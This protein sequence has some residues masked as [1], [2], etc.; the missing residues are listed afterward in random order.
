MIDRI[1]RRAA[2]VAM[3]LFVTLGIV[4]SAGR[5]AAQCATITVVN[6]A[7][8][9]IDVTFAD[10]NTPVTTMTTGTI[11]GGGGFVVLT[12]PTTWLGFASYTR[13]GGGFPIP[14]TAANTCTPFNPAPCASVGI[15]GVMLRCCAQACWDPLTCTVTFS[16]CG[17]C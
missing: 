17:P 14:F 4:F 16:A 12:V 3:M 13:T 9:A 1:S 6:N 5:A 10:N 7:N 15:P 2:M 11:A 8:C